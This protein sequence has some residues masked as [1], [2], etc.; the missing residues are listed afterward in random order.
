M[1][2]DI[3]NYLYYFIVLFLKR[4]KKSTQ[5]AAKNKIDISR[6]PMQKKNTARHVGIWMVFFL[7]RNVKFAFLSKKR[8]SRRDAELIFIAI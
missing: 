2:K 7:S 3:Q 6:T 1:V 4:E 8:V 5:V